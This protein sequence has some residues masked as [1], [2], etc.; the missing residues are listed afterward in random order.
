MNREIINWIEEF[1]ETNPSTSIQKITE[2]VGD[3][4]GD[5]PDKEFVNRLLLV[6]SEEGVVERV[7]DSIFYKYHRKYLT[8]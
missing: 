5:I 4:L 2:L 7:G 8:S 1:I 6:L 3:V